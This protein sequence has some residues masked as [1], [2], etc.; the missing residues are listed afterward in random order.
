[1]GSDGS[2]SPVYGLWP[3]VLNDAAE[4]PYVTQ[5][6][7]EGLPGV[8]RGIELI[9]GVIAQLQPILYRNEVDIKAPTER[10][11]TPPLLLDPDPLWHG[12]PV[13]LSAM[14]SAMAWHGNG[15][16]YKGPEVSDGRGYPTRLPL[17]D[18]A[19]VSWDP[20]Q[21][22][23]ATYMVEGWQPVEP[24]DMFHAPMT[25][26]AGYRMGRGI[27][28]RFQSTLRLMVVTEKAQYVVMKD[29]Q[30][31]GI[32]SLGIDVTPQEAN[33]YKQGFLK[34]VSESSV[35][36]MGN[37]DFK[38]VQWSANDLSMVPTREFNLRLA[39]DMTGVPPYLLGVPSESRVYANME[40]EWANFIRVTL[41]RYL[42][43][44]ESAWSKCFPR[45]T[46]VRF[47]VDQ[48]LRAD[49]AAR[50]AVYTAADAIGAMTVDE[51][52]AF[53]F[54]E[55]L[56][57]AQKQQIAASKATISVTADAPKDNE[58]VDDGEEEASTDDDA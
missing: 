21:P 24:G 25:A 51:I 1:M 8:G 13:W 46:S 23:G 47:R 55:P 38:P 18:P 53:E 49:A 42:A 41:G 33:E 54:W 50:W 28:E 6:I 31:M 58:E 43:P 27:L 7:A 48:L 44:L 9:A 36:A 2:A 17:L 45:G 56:T 10:L 39:S 57:P 52:R 12:L 20:T 22:D 14:V 26:R 37:A 16:A 4:V 3:G 5:E 15:F 34:A 29:G 35:A 30:P 32:I 40:T 19:L 11:P